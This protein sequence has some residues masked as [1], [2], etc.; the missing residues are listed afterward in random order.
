MLTNPPVILLISTIVVVV[1]L[2][3]VIKK[4]T[5]PHMTNISFLTTVENDKE[6]EESCSDKLNNL[7]NLLIEK[8]NVLKE[9]KSNRK[10][11]CLKQTTEIEKE[12]GAINDKILKFQP[13]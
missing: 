9:M 11:E 7:K 8:K 12:I 4:K 1:V 10:K 13:L 3:S 2:I 5:I 6:N